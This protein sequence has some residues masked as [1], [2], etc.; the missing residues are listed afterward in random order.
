MAKMTGRERVMAMIQQNPVDCLPCLPITMGFA[1]DCINARYFD[2]AMDYRVQVDA[3]IEV[4]DFFDFDHV[5]VISDPAV[6]AADCGAEFVTFPNE[7]PTLDEARALLRDKARLKQ[8][9]SPD[10]T[11]GR[12]MSNRL[13]ALRSLKE[14][15][16][17]SRL[18]EGWIEGPCAQ[19]ANLRGL[20]ALIADFNGDRAF[21]H[22]LFQFA[23]EMELWFA[24][25]QISVGADIIGIGDASS[26]L[27]DPAHY[28][29]FVFPYQKDLIDR[30]HGNGGYVR[31][32]SP[33]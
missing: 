33:H 22:D 5:S 11:A 28:A 19:A 14:R 30:V 27:I 13:E 2:Y 7:P 8:L 3:Q 4:S 16:G 12:R 6:E 1:S 25:E 32:I 29:E 15:V 17:G 24:R 10:P 23:V 18:I 20:N 26:S 9:R 21:A 31:L